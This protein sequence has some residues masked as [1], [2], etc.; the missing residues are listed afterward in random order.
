MFQFSKYQTAVSL[1]VPVSKK[2]DFI[3]YTADQLSGLLYK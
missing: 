1:Q 3:L 2:L